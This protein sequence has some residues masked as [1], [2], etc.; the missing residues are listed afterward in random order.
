MTTEQKVM[1]D[2]VNAY[3]E[4]HYSTGP[5]WGLVVEAYTDEEILEEIAHCKTATD[6]VDAMR[7]VAA[8]YVRMSDAVRDV[9]RAYSIRSENF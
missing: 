5:G 7:K 3:A 1:I 4:A 8:E 6:A 9:A 2:A